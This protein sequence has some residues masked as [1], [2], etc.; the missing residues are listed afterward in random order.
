MTMRVLQ[1]SPL[2]RVPSH[3]WPAV[4]LAMAMVLRV[5]VTEAAQFDCDDLAEDMELCIEDILSEMEL[6][7]ASS[8][9]FRFSENCLWSH[10]G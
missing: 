4:G 6:L 5:L 1:H 8:L 2:I 9:I 10:A 3:F 7:L